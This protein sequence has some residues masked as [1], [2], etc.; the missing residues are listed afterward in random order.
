MRS[1]PWSILRFEIY[2]AIEWTRVA[3]SH[4]KDTGSDNGMRVLKIESL[5][6]PNGHRY[7]DT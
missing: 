2:G 3:G 6:T 1:A 4:V 7:S 5:A